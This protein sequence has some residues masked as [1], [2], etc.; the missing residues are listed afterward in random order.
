[1]LRGS[2]LTKIKKRTVGRM[3]LFKT[4]KYL[5]VRKDAGMGVGTLFIEGLG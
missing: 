3:R 4:E 5:G 2:F 1:M